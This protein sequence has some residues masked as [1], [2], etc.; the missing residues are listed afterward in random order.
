MPPARWDHTTPRRKPYWPTCT[1]TERNSASVP[2]WV[3]VFYIL[4]YRGYVM[5]MFT[6][7]ML[8]AAVLSVASSVLSN[9]LFA[10]RSRLVVAEIRRAGHAVSERH[11]LTVLDSH[12]VG[13]SDRGA[14]S[15]F[16]KLDEYDIAFAMA[17]DV[18]GVTYYFL[19]PNA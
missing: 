16:K 9:K 10:K 4:A 8:A 11:L 6:V 2:V 17:E 12:G 3:K 15:F 19:G 5:T 13:L 1:D 18:E 14:K 7:S